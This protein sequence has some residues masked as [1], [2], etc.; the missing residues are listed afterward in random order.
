VP[1]ADDEHVELVF[2]IRERIG[3]DPMIAGPRVTG[4][5]STRWVPTTASPS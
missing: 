4:A 3:H 5:C 2:M 1:S